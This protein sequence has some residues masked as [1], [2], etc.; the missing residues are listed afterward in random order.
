[1]TDRHAGYLVTL[2]R[3]IRE[4]DAE[5]IMAAIHMIKGV[6]SVKPVVA[7]IGLHIAAERRDGDWRTALS[8]LIAD[9]PADV[10]RA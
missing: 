5:A 1:M 4:D 8:R 9:G 7:D 6:I 2:D 3:D 10:P